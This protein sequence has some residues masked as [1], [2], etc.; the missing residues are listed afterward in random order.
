M[1][2]PAAGTF[3][4]NRVSPHERDTL[5]QA[6]PIRAMPSTRKETAMDAMNVSPADQNDGAATE[7]INPSE[8]EKHSPEDTSKEDAN[9]EGAEDEPPA[10]H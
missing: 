6:Y 8:D 10:R 2:T 3:G 7:M 9:D 1:I 5:R 4:Y